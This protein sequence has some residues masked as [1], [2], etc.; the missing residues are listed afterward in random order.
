[1]RKNEEKPRSADTD[2][3]GRVRLPVS[4]RVLD[5]LD[6]PVGAFGRISFVEAAGNRE[7]TVEG[8][9]GLSEY[10]EKMISLELCDGTMTISG[11]GLELRSF[12]GGKVSVNGVI[13]SIE[14]GREE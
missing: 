11:A 7:V 9:V 14:W 2:D 13:R 3:G 12:S 10:G 5:A 6:F 1:M 4:Q 8:C